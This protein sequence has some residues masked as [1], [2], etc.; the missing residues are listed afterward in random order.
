MLRL[1]RE[2]VIHKKQQNPHEIKHTW[3]KDS[4]LCLWRCAAGRR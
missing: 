1:G 4:D 2:E 3:Y